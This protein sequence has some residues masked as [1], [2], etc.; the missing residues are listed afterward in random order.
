L[1]RAKNIEVAEGNG[2][3]AVAFEKRLTVKFADVLGDAVRGNGLRLHSFDLGKN[4]RLTIGGRGGGK[5]D[6][7]D[8]LLLCSHKNVEGALNIDAIG[9]QGILHRPRHGSPGGKMQHVLRF[10][11][12]VAHGFDVG[13]AAFDERNLVADIGEVF[14]LPGRKVV[15]HD[16]AMPALNQFVHRVGAD[17]ACPARHHVTH[18]QYPPLKNL[19]NCFG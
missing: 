8:S 12:G 7:F 16:N 14:F 3:E 6:A 9:L 1:A 2:F 15:E 5:H 17:E 11:H 18:S 10:V 13:D 4:G 19:R